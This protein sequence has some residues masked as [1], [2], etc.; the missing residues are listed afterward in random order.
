MSE[1]TIDRGDALTDEH[2][3]APE[4]D[5]KVE[6][7]AAA[8]PEKTEEEQIE[9]GLAKEETSRDEKGKFAKKDHIPVD[10]HKA[11]LE[12]ERDA[13]EAAERRA[14][15]LEAQLRK[16]AKSVD[17]SKME[18][19]VEVLEKQHTKLLLDG[20]ADKAAAVMKEI[21]KAE[22]QIA[23]IEADE[24]VAAATTQA[25][26]QV[27]M[28][29]VIARL[30]ADNSFFNP[31][32]DDFDQDLVD[33]VLAEQGRLM[34]SDRMT[35]SAALSKAATKIISK[36]QTPVSDD[37]G[38]KGLAAAKSA[39]RKA[40]QVAKNLD[41]AKKQPPSLKD[42]GLDSDKAG[43]NAESG[44]VRNMTSEEWAALPEATRAK[45]RGDTL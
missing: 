18:D 32:S 21:R 3:N 35:A 4:P 2:I 26:E 16:E 9:E 28:D 43:K 11:V 25:V 1:E 15:E 31:D 38:A 30:E 27:R 13:R 20:E 19:A 37:G 36:L 8:A 14:A 34:R 29:A 42:T 24:K 41:T 33:L 12:K 44:D 7:K 10:R 23:T 45:L 6:D 40:Q 17:V 39:D 22:R 5:D